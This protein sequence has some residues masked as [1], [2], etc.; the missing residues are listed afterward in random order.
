LT[1]LDVIGVKIDERAPT[2]TV[3]EKITNYSKENNCFVQ[4]FDPE[5][6]VGKDHLLWAIEKAKSRFEDDENRADSLEMEI[7]LCSSGERQIKNAIKK[8]GLKD[9]SDKAAVVTNCDTDGL[10]DHIGWERDDD[11]LVPSID[12]LKNYGVSEIEIGS[13]DKPFDLVFE[14]MATSEI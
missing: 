5:M 1:D 2:D 9:M 6:V 7:L 14:I 8:M 11:I 10:L 3:F 4:I 13:T 12:K